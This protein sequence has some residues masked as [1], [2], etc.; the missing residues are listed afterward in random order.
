M[1]SATK[2]SDMSP[3]EYSKYR[4][5]IGLDKLDGWDTWRGNNVKWNVPAN[6][7]DIP[8]EARIRLLRDNHE[9]RKLQE[10]DLAE[11]YARELLW[12]DKGTY[13]EYRNLYVQTGDEMYMERMLERVELDA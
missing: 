9:M 13:E 7:I 12:G 4:R 2:L 1:A 8:Q 5:E 3:K 6:S 10:A 11:I